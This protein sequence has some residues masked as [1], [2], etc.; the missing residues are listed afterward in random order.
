MFHL[1]FPSMRLS[2]DGAVELAR[3]ER[4]EECEFEE[5]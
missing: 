3:C 4:E 5:R 2:D 1:E